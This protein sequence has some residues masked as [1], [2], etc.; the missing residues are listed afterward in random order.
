MAVPAEPLLVAVVLG[1][2]G[3]LLWAGS[4][5]I[6]LRQQRELWRFASSTGKIV[7]AEVRLAPP[8]WYN[9]LLGAS[10]ADSSDESV[11]G[12][13]RSDHQHGD[14]PIV[15]Y[16]YTVAGETYTSDTIWPAGIE[17]VSDRL[18]SGVG[19][20]PQRVVSR[21]VV[22]DEVTVHYDPDDPG[23]AFLR[24]DRNVAG[25]MALLVV[26]TLP[27]AAVVQVLA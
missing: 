14:V 5:W 15:E 26:G 27:V 6:L 23:V 20:F 24:R 8:P 17:P 7:T 3:V 13:A 21:Y 1:G 18:L 25:A 10:Q 19:N 12:V 11:S 2:I 22:G 9:R 4:L 16:E